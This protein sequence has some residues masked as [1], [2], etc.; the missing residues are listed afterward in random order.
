[1]TDGSAIVAEMPGTG[2]NTTDDVTINVKV[3]N[4]FFIK[5]SGI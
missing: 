2:K 4:F 5:T 3:N 1:V